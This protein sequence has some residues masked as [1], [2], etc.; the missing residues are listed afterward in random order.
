MRAHHLV[1]RPSQ[2]LANAPE[3]A[4]EERCA[5]EISA[6]N[7]AS[8]AAAVS[9]SRT[10]ARPGYVASKLASV[11][12]VVSGARGPSSAGPG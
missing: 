9:G 4:A 7:R 2:D 11:S 10:T 3:A 8:A 6:T 1:N 12:A 5:S